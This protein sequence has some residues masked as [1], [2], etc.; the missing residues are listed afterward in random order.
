[1]WNEEEKGQRYPNFIKESQAAYKT[2]EDPALG[3][4]FSKKQGEYT[5]ED[6]YVLP[7]ECRAELI[8]GVI[9]DMA[10]PDYIHQVIAFQIAVQLDAW[11][12]KKKGSCMVIVSPA[13]VRLDKDDKTMVQPDV[14]VICG[15]ENT[16]S[17]G[18]NKGPEEDQ[19]K[20]SE[21]LHAFWRAPDMAIEVLSPSSDKKDRI[22]KYRKYKKA[23]V[24]EYWVV[25][26][27]S[28]IV[29]AHWFAG[30]AGTSVYTYQDEIPVR[31]FDG[32]CRVSLRDIPQS[33]R[34][35][36]KLGITDR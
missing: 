3:R 31:I 23:G 33:E 20:E 22:V 35:L 21:A 32:A 34:L 7:D 29:A 6:Y 14:F 11:I 4:L 13:D 5:V 12:K 1:M 28:E 17:Y 8:D 30:D 26:P 24:K 27:K 36:T 9:Y 25:D 2:P 16:D 15:K 18:E 19:K 10:A